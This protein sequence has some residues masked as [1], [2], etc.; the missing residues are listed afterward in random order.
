MNPWKVI[1]ATL[2]IF[3]AGLVV[4]GLVGNRTARIDATA[5]KPVNVQASNPSQ[6]RL[7]EL[8][9]RMDRELELTPEQHAHIEKIIATS[10]ERT[11]KLWSPI[12]QEMHHETQKVCEEIR[13]EL[14][15]E[16]KTKFD[17]FSKM[18]PERRRNHPQTNAPAPTG[19]G[20]NFIFNLPANQ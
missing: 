3:G 5:A 14:T 4:G 18:R 9:R 12:A 8:L 11:Q 15:P 6:N 19:G 13:D 20:T 10:Q 7:R 16:Q 17:T 1:F 2:V